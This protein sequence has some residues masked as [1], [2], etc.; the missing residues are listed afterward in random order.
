[1]NGGMNMKRNR[2][3]S[4]AK[5]H[6]GG[7]LRRRGVLLVFSLV[8]VATIVSV[9][10]WRQLPEGVVKAR[11]WTTDASR[12]HH[13]YAVAAMDIEVVLQVTPEYRMMFRYG[14]D[15]PQYRILYRKA[16]LKVAAA[17]QRVGREM[18]YSAVLCS[19]SSHLPDITGR[20]AVTLVNPSPD[21]C[22]VADLSGRPFTG[23]VISVRV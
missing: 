18:G 6:D 19:P 14:Y 13:A 4:Q 9:M 2:T 7:C 5:P 16:R 12:T 17:A 22:P 23:D 1:M 10:L 21:F 20:V 11:L 8:I 3:E 15:S